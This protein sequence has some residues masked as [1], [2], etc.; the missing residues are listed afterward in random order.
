MIEIQAAEDPRIEE[1]THLRETTLLSRNLSL[2][3]SEKI[4]LKV[5][6]NNI[7]IHKI[8]C[9]KDFAK[10]HN[11]QGSSVFIASREILN[12]IAGFKTEF[13]VLLLIER[14]NNCSLASLG[15]KILAMNG[16]ASPENVGSII[17]SAAAF[18]VTSALIDQ[19]TCSPF[20]RR[21]VRVSMGNIFSMRINQA[22]NFLE[23]LGRLKQLG[24][25]IISTAN[26]TDAIS[27]NEYKFPEKIVLIIGSEGHGI[28]QEIINFSEVVLKIPINE[29]VAHLNASNAAAIFLS[30][31]SS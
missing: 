23:S 26:I 6:H 21:C 2:V 5:I 29:N 24:Y 8:L 22:E 27:V 11:L 9:T 1:F 19:K 13:D 14:P 31:I 18:N 3:E 4:Y 15:D 7:F 16:I 28:E 20:L 12:T 10:K 30:R 17:R 25:T